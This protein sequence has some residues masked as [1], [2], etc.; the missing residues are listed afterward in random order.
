M[1]SSEIIKKI[2]SYSVFAFLLPLLTL[3]SCLLLYKMLGNIEVY[4]TWNWNEKKIEIPLNYYNVDASSL[5]DCP[6]YKYQIYALTVDNKLLYI[7]D[8]DELSFN[9]EKLKVLKENN[10]VKA[11]I[12]EQGENINYKCVKNYKYLYSIINNF[13]FLE[14]ILIHIKKKKKLFFLQLKNH[15]FMERFQ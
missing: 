12:Y 6:K 10:K 5:V 13:N 4:P 14:K 2:K 9:Q 8:F 3:N 15:I 11:E 1:K 7:E